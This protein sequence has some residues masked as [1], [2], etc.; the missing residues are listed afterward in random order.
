MNAFTTEITY[1]KIVE[2]RNKK[3]THIP[4]N[5]PTTDSNKEN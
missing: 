2:K 3:K 4:R 5:S 1:A